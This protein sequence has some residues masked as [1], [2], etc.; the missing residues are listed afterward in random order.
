[1]A[2]SHGKQAKQIAAATKLVAGL[3]ERL[4]LDASV[5]LW[6]GSRLPLGRNVS[7]SFELHIASPGVIGS[8]LRRPTLDTIIRH[9]VN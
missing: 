8:I 6:D 3:A 4:N 1:M 5:R 7:S 2:G 9:Y